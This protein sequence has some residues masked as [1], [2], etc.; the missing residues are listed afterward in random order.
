MQMWVMQRYQ[1]S[2]AASSG[3]EP[4][5]HVPSGTPRPTSLCLLSQ[6]VVSS[7]TER[8]E[9]MNVLHPGCH[10]INGVKNNSQ[11]ACVTNIKP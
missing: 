1:L 9:V 2:L 5:A 10:V 6:L 8:A 3:Q 11:S 4:P 7:E